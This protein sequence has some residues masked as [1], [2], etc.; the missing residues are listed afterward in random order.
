MGAV[1]GAFG[2]VCVLVAWRIWDER[3]SRD[4][5]RQTQCV[6]NVKQ[7]TMALKTYADDNDQKL[8]I[9]NVPTKTVGTWLGRTDLISYEGRPPALAIWPTILDPYIKSMGIAACPSA[10]ATEAKPYSYFFNRRLSG[11]PATA[12]LDPSQY[13]MIGDWVPYGPRE[14]ATST[15]WDI[16]RS[17]RSLPAGSWEAAERHSGRGTSGAG[18][19]YGFVDGHAK[20]VKRWQIIQGMQVRGGR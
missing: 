19:I 13:I 11:L 15:S 18:A 20:R 10:R 4:R 6:S 7:L 5:A 9:L 8:P 2:M 14:V 12:V 1:I 16:A 3:G 17:E